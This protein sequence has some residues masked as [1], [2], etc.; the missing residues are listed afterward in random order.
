MTICPCIQIEAM[1]AT[2]QALSNEYN[3]K[4]AQ[5]VARDEDWQSLLNCLDPK[6]GETGVH[7][8]FISHD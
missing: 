2:V 3:R 8:H 5:M 6:N 1:E 4:L 7:Y